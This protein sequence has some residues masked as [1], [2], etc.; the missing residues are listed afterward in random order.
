MQNLHIFVDSVKGRFINDITQKMGFL[1]PPPPS[2]IKFMQN[3]F[4]LYRG[5]TYGGDGCHLRT[6]SK[7]IA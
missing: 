2:D 7:W 3:I 5:V 4:F 1:Y 6:T